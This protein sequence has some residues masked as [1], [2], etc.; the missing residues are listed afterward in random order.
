M[1]FCETNPTGLWRNTRK[2]TGRAGRNVGTTT[3]P[4]E[5]ISLPETSTPHTA[6]RTQWGFSQVREEILAAGIGSRRQALRPVDPRVPTTKR[7][8]FPER[9]RPLTL[10]NEPNGILV[11][12]AKVFQTTG[13]DRVGKSCVRFTLTSRRRNEPTSLVS[14]GARDYKTYPMGLWGTSRRNI[15]WKTRHLRENPSTKR[16]HFLPKPRRLTLQN[17][18]NGT[19]VKC[20]KVFQAT[21]SD[22]VG[23]SC[24][25]WTL[26]SRRRSEPTSLVSLGARDY[27]TNPMGLWGIS[28]RNMGPTC[29]RTNATPPRE[30][31][32]ETNPFPC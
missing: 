16:T 30:P 15:A 4:N 20:A 32:H 24:V 26:T 12:C 9:H 23:K 28:P 31:V 5:P 14:L 25:R 22:R 17:E 19:L 29:H 2:N 18:P 3:S 10:Q 11:K 13:S 1:H 8:H 21:G 6:K 27:K 7:T